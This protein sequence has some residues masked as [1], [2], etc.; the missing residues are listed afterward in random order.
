MSDLSW[1]VEDAANQRELGP[2]RALETWLAAHSEWRLPKHDDASDIVIPSLGTY[3]FPPELLPEFFKHVE[4]CRRA[5]VWFNIME[6]QRPDRPSGLLIDLDLVQS[7]A[8]RILNTERIQQCVNVLL[9]ELSLLVALPSTPVHVF[10]SQRPEITRIINGENSTNSANSAQWKDGLHIAVP[11]LLMDRGLKKYLMQQLAATLLQKTLRG[12]DGLDV[13]NAVDIGAASAPMLLQGAAKRERRP[14]PIVSVWEFTSGDGFPMLRERTSNLDAYNLAYEASL[15]Y[16][17]TYADD[18]TPLVTKVPVAELSEH[19][20]P[21]RAFREREAQLARRDH[22]GAVELDD[23]LDAEESIS[24]LSHDNPDARDLHAILR[25]IPPTTID[26]RNKWRDVIFA[27]ASASERFYPL[28]VWFTQR[29]PKRWKRDELDAVW[30]HACSRK[31]GKLLPGQLQDETDAPTGAVTFRSLHHWAREARPKDYQEAL[32]Q[33]YGHRLYLDAVESEGELTDLSR[34]NLLYSLLKDTFAVVHIESKYYWY[35]FVRPSGGS[36]PS[37]CAANGRSDSAEIFKWRYE[38]EQPT[39][40]VL[41]LMERVPVVLRRIIDQI[42]DKQDQAR[43]QNKADTVKWYQKTIANLRRSAKNLE[44]IRTAS[45]VIRTAAHVFHAHC[46]DFASRLNADPMLLGVGNGVLRLGPNPELL[47]GFHEHYVSLKTEARWRPYD[48]ADPW[49]RYVEERFAEMYPEPDAR[50]YIWKYWASALDGRVK[51]ALFLAIHAPGGEGKSTALESMLAAL[52]ELATKLSQGLL[53]GEREKSNEANAAKMDML[54]KR[55]GYFSELDKD[56]TVTEGAFKENTGGEHVTGRSPYDRKQMKF[57]PTMRFMLITNKRLVPQTN[58]HGF[59]RR[60]LWYYGKV[61]FVDNPDP[62]NPA[63]RKADPTLLEHT[64]HTQEWKDAFLSVLVHHYVELTV[65]HGGHL[66]NV[67]CPSI[68]RDT[69]HY[70]NQFDVINRFICEKVVKAPAGREDAPQYRCDIRTLQSELSQWCMRAEGAS[71][72]H[73]NADEI[74]KELRESRIKRFIQESHG[75]LF[76][77]GVR[78]LSAHEELLPGETGFQVQKETA[79][80]VP[81]PAPP[82]VVDDAPSLTEDAPPPGEY[83]VV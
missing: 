65:K 14:Y 67:P 29:L 46:R 21:V 2:R 69:E 26:H 1:A 80:D 32:A 50:N 3:T 61:R 40:L 59:W 77:K 13:E 16:V 38:G 19:E 20:A 6:K 42:K 73:L 51:E 11:S 15:N 35:E 10:V 27:I 60:L 31:R 24:L 81:V 8:E 17:A 39:S 70:R 9:K 76:V 55:F 66:R 62:N 74:T 7:K 47:K 75:E 45:S 82:P 28:A 79:D 37:G 4:A 41:Y 63:E 34:A 22:F 53:V 5:Q 56:T 58:T 54:G 52:G 33:S 48:A 64:I 71:V 43:E 23:L 36:A 30:A 57:L 68:Q 78:V 72:R 49:I 25:I 83:D 44:N 12:V 18:T